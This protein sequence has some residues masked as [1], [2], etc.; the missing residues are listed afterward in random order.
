MSCF[1]SCQPQSILSNFCHCV[2]YYYYSGE[3]LPSVLRWR[4]EG[5]GHG[6]QVKSI[7]APQGVMSATGSTPR[8]RSSKRSGRPIN[9]H[10]SPW[11]WKSLIIKLLHH[12]WSFN[13]DFNLHTR[14]IVSGM[15]LWIE[16]VSH[17]QA[18]CFKVNC[19]LIFSFWKVTPS[20]WQLHFI[21]ALTQPGKL[22]LAKHSCFQ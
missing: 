13:D 11:P 10:L 8:D 17:V 5:W 15:L 1:S 6:G 16:V 20:F 14:Q 7:P 22:I 4:E 21:N 2:Y 3:N 19:T 12:H 9:D 18:G